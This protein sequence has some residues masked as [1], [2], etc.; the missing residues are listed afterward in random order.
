MQ[1]DN[2]KKSVIFQS[3]RTWPKATRHNVRGESKIATSALLRHLPTETAAS[4]SQIELDHFQRMM[5][6]L[7][8][9]QTQNTVPFYDNDPL[10]AI[11]KDRIKRTLSR[12]I[13]RTMAQRHMGDSVEQ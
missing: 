1:F 7:Q 2:I 8:K 3:T 6:F 10:Q 5:R 12:Q 11:H 9:I 13:P 4:D